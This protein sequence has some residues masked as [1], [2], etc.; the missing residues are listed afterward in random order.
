MSVARVA[1]YVLC[2]GL[3]A[4]YGWKAVAVLAGAAIV[5]HVVYY[6]KHGKWIELD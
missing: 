6:L 1:A 3:L 4:V 2:F 5:A